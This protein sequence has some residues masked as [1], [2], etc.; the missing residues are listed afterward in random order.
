MA[1]F[2]HNVRYAG[3][4][5]RLFFQTERNGRIQGLIAIVV[6]IAGVACGLS[7]M[8]WVV[9]GICIGL[10]IGL[11]MINSAIEKLCNLI[12]TEYN[13]AVKVI[14]DISAGAVLWVSV[15]AAIIGAC[16]FLPHF[17]GLFSSGGHA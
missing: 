15:I 13:P 3:E 2:I 11:E 12:T 14:K 9:T 10:V 6:I 7:V 16:I 17:Y 8:E 1:N 4:G 5:I